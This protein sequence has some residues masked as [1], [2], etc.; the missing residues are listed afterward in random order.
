MRPDKDSCAA[1]PRKSAVAATPIGV[2]SKDGLAADHTTRDSGATAT[3]GSREIRVIVCAGV[4]HERTVHHVR[5]FHPWRK[6]RVV[7]A[8]VGGNVQRRQVAE[9]PV[10]PW[11]AVPFRPLGIQMPTRS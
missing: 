1:P 6:H 8:T 4:N 9:M 7:G 5:K 2:R 3:E 10:T 11:L